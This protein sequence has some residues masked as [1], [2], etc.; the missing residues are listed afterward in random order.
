M[1]CI[2]RGTLIGTDVQIRQTC[3]RRCV[4]C[5]TNLLLCTKAYIRAVIESKTK[6]G[7]IVQPHE[8]WLNAT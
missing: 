8:T 3:Q 1:Y 2:V 7:F 6:L 4:L 5:K